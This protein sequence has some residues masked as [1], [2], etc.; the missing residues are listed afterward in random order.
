M[1]MSARYEIIGCDQ[2]SPEWF[3]ARRGIPTAS[4]YKDILAQGEGKMR[5]KYMKQ[6][7]GEIITGKTM[8]AYSN[9]RMDDGNELEPDLR[10]QYLS[11]RD[12]NFHDT[13]IVQVGFL[14]MNPA[15]C[16]TGCSPDGLIGEDGM[17]EFKTAE[18]TVL[19][20]ILRSGTAPATHM[21]QVQ[22]QLWI[23]GRKWCDLVIGWPKMPLSITRVERNDTYMATLSMAVKTFNSELAD[24]VAW[25]RRL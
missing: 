4:R 19:I 9:E 8:K 16:A 7:A 6:L 12:Y 2:G 18:P 5:N 17:V 15:L 20:D 13:D 1:T 25:L 24:M 3:E 10:N 21:P 14:K 22:G 23:S 11:E